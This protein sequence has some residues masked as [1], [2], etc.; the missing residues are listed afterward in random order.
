MYS[1][2]STVKKF[3]V[4]A[5]AASVALVCFGF[6]A[7]VLAQTA[8]Q[9]VQQISVFETSE[10]SQIETVRERWAS[11]F[12]GDSNRPLN[13]NMVKQ[14]ADINEEAKEL[15]STMNYF[16]DDIWSDL[17]LDS[18]TVAEK[19]KQGVN[20]YATYNR[21]FTL[22]RAFKLQG[23]ELYGDAE[24]REIIVEVL[25]KLNE[26]YY[27]V[28]APEY[29]NW[30]QWELGISR[31]VQNTLVIMY[32]DI[33]YEIVDNYVDAT[34]YFVPNPTHLSEGYGAP[35]SSAPL[36]WES[37]GG[38][39]TD[40][41]QVVLVR[42]LL[43]N[44][45]DDVKRSV[46]ALSS[47][48]PFV[49]SGDGFYSDGS[50]IQHKDLPYSGTYGQVMLEGLGM[51]LG[52]VAN[53]EFEAT[54]PELEKIYPLMMDTFAP[55]LVDG[56]MSDMVNGR[57]VSR[58]TGQNDLIGES[59]LGAMMLYVDGAPIEYQD[60]LT[61]FIKNQL[62]SKGGFEKSRFMS[63]HQTA[64]R[65]MMTREMKEVPTISHKQFP[66]MDRVI[67]HRNDWSFGIAMHSD[68]VGNYESINGENL[69]GWYTA[70]GMT[71]LYNQQDHFNSGY[72]AVVDPMKHA[73]TTVLLTERENASGQLSAQRDGRN[74]AMDWTGGTSLDSYGVTGMKFVNFNRELSAKKSWFMF[75]NEV[76]AL[77]ADIQNSSSDKAITTIENRIVNHEAILTIDGETVQGNYTGQAKHFEIINDTNKTAR[78]GYPVVQYSILDDAHIDINK[79]CRSGDW[80]DIGTSKGEVEACF[81]EVTTEHNEEDN[82]Y[83]YMVTPNRDKPTEA[84]TVVA[85]TGDVQAVYHD[86]LGIFAA[87]FFDDAKAGSIEAHDEMSIMTQEHN[88][89]V[90]VSISDPTRSWF[91]VDFTIDGQFE[92]AEDFDNRVNLDVNEVSVD[93]DDLAGSSYEF[94]LKRID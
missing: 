52:A 22:A 49:E 4:S 58:S 85:N 83:A 34:R 78:D 20:L 17:P 41:A 55:L 68:R 29:G 75:D 65:L 11:Y 38:N 35:Y 77:G 81:Y 46:E 37:T 61:T 63:V 44:N 19:Q 45:H 87:N 18:E 31:T 16:S 6:T 24:L 15:L 26:D 73:G 56:R 66:N 86:E 5:L 13:E 62:A 84:I 43:D 90:K 79:V 14:I 12:L 64:D 69:K 82:S 48:I 93:L 54:D 89:F 59:I 42:G 10:K 30:W 91:D 53:T 74:G 1:K 47:V 25:A 57:A 21:I 88:G 51:L 67:H 70:D 27:H 76:V 3:K 50:Y 28:G 8:Q 33:P 39:R 9:E 72:W 36:A 2:E 94:I 92:L 23:G 80:S 71:Y 60:K 40:N 7:P 32:D